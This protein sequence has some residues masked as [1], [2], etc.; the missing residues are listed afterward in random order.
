ML[1]QYLIG[2]CAIAWFTV[3]GVV[4]PCLAD[5][6]RIGIGSDL[7]PYVFSKPRVGLEVEIIREALRAAGHEADFVFLPNMRFTIEFAQ[8]NVDGI[9]V[10]T[11]FDLAADS[12]RPSFGSRTTV[13]Y[14]NYAIF[15]KKRKISVN[16]IADLA[17]LNVLGFNNATKFLEPEFA[18]LMED[19]PLYL[20]V[21]DQSRQVLMLFNKRVDVVVADKLIFNYW[22]TRLIRLGAVELLDMRKRLEF[23][24]IF[25]PAPRS[26][27]FADQTLRDDFD[28]GLSEI[29]R[30]GLRD[31][32]ENRYGGVGVWGR[33]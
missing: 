28:R 3:F 18:A 22:L 26:V 14:N 7:A 4:S 17:G 23:A 5:T 2:L 10:N 1:Q 33:L 30:N 15:L 11:E 27:Q 9:A 19:N 8:G 21:T 25:A 24:R 20:E 32:I 29:I 16:S 12:G 6:V 13:V 31:A